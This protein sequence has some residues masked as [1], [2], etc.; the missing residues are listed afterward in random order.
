MIKEK[1]YYDIICDRCGKSLTNESGD[2]YLDS[3]IAVFI[4]ILSEWL[5][6]DGK[7]YCPDCYEVDEETGDYVPK[8]GGEK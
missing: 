1:T 4:A 8:E 3:N 7:H 5:I 6:I 2:C